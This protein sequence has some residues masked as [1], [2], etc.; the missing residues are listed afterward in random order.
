MNQFD[1][2]QLIALFGWLI[3]A[4]G[5]LAAQRLNWKAGLRMALIW[6]ALFTGAALVF[7]LLMD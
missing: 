6:G 1:I 3:L 7:M 2:V 5:A 4:G